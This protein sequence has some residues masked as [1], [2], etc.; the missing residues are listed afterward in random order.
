M[1]GTPPSSV[2]TPPDVE[3]EAGYG[4]ALSLQSH[5][6]PAEDLNSNAGL[7]DSPGKKILQHSWDSGSKFFKLI[8]MVQK[9]SLWQ[10]IIKHDCL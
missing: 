5:C 10:N 2:P 1:P 3:T 6:Q 4:E 7:S 9:K 8:F